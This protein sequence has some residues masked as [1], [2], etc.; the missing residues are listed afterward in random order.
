VVS[1]KSKKPAQVWGKRSA[2]FYTGL[3][4]DEVLVHV[5]TGQRF[6]GALIGVDTYDL[7]IRQ[8]SGLEVLIPKGNVVYVHPALT[9]TTVEER[10]A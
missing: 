4:G 7:V 2:E 1:E 6:R 9:K 10:D 8:A 5:V 3:E